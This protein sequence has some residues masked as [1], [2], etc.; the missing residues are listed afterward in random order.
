MPP[1]VKRGLHKSDA[2]LKHRLTGAH[3]SSRVGCKALACGT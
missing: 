2:M 1:T 3:A